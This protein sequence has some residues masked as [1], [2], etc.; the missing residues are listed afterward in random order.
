MHSWQQV[1]APTVLKHPW[2]GCTGQ[3]RASSRHSSGSLLQLGITLH[4]LTHARLCCALPPLRPPLHQNLVRPDEDE[5]A[6]TAKETLEALNR[7]V[8][9]KLAVQNPS[10]LPEQP[11][12]PTYIKY[13]PSQQGAAY[14]SGAK[15]RIIK[16]QDMPVSVSLAGG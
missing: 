3:V 6:K 13:T 10:T 1:L 8:T 16:M 9:N 4:L 5:V 7:R 2:V 11:G 12:A 15:Q 14:A